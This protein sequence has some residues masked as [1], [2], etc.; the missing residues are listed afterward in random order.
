MIPP[1]ALCKGG[2]TTETFSTMGRMVLKA[3]QA[4]SADVELLNSSDG[5]SSDAPLFSKIGAESV[6]IE[7]SESFTLLCGS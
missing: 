6:A 4:F 7:A 3:L 1:M 5:T 2:K